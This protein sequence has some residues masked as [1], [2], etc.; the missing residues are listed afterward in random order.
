MNSP[1]L[2]PL[3]VTTVVAVLG[4]FTAHRLT[5][6]RDRANK[7]RELRTQYLIEA[8]RKLERAVHR[9]DTTASGPELES[10]VADIHLFGSARQV[11]LVQAFVQQFTTTKTGDVSD[12]LTDLRRDL[13]A[14]LQ[15]ETVPNKVAFIRIKPPGA[16][17]SPEPPAPGNV[18]LVFP[19]AG[20][21]TSDNADENA[22]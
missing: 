13:R 16:L 20:G 9:E 11:E 15:L 5:A 21:K 4:W 6:H 14:E 1:L 8:Y 7:R 19:Q 10:A 3:L 22:S 12:L 18:I 17:S 2:L